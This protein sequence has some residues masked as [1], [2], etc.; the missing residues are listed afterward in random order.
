[1]YGSVD[2]NVTRGSQNPDP[3]SISPRSNAS[4]EYLTTCESKGDKGKNE[5]WGLRQDEKLLH[6]KGNNQ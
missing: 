1:M 3:P 2:E 5:L 4:I 6:S